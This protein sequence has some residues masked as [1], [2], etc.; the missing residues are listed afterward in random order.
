MLHQIKINFKKI[1]ISLGLTI[2]MMTILASV[3]SSVRA[4]SYSLQYEL[5]SWEL[6]TEFMSMLYPL[7]VV[8]P[9]CWDLYAERKDNFLLY[10]ASRTSIKNYLLAKWIAY[11]VGAF[12]IILVPSILSAFFVLYIKDPIT[13]FLENPFLHVFAESF[14]EKPWIYLS[15][16]SLWRSILGVVMMTFGFVLALFY[17]NLFVI[18]IGPFVYS[19]L[20][21]FILAVLRLERYRLVTAFDPTNLSPEAISL[22]SFLVGPG[23]LIVTIV[24]TGMVLSC[25][26][27]II[28]V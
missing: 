13:P 11:A 4:Q 27:R 17:K 19:I 24:L 1:I 8:I 25:K 21:N 12:L 20:E 9:L 5:E 7:L 14:I 22:A 15:L 18:L 2:A 26:N 10:V 28:S 3:L 23:L 6:G 16:L